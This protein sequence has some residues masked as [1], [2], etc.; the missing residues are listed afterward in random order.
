M[1]TL[2]CGS[3]AGARSSRGYQ[4]SGYMALDIYKD[5]RGCL[6]YLGIT[7]LSIFLMFF[8]MFFKYAQDLFDYLTYYYPSSERRRQG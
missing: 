2:L 1:F 4:H 3:V 7:V 6:S 5:Q 8:I